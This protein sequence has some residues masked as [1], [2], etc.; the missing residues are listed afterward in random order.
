MVMRIIQV[1]LGLIG[2]AIGYSF[3]YMLGRL[4]L[5]GLMPHT[6]WNVLCGT[7]ILIF[8][9]A[10]FLLTPWLAG[11]TRRAV[12]F[13]EGVLQRTPIQDLAGG[14]IG[15]IVGLVIAALLGAPLSHIPWVGTYLPI[16]LS[17]LFG[18]LGLSVGVKKKDDIATLFSTIKLGSK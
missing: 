2:A 15:L 6:A 1:V 17:I 10:M 14:A 11:A 4:Q 5:P 12:H 18:Y 16:L 3:T 8:A 7:I 13:F 9:V